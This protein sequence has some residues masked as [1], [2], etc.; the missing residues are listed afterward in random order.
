MLNLRLDEYRK[1]APAVTA[2][3]R[4][5]AQFLHGEHLFDPRFLPYGSQL[6]PL[7]AALAVLGADAEPVGSRQKIARWYWCGRSG[8]GELYGG[9]TENRFARDLPDLISWVHGDGDEPR[10][11]QEA[12]FFASRLRSLRT[13]GSAAYKGLYALLIKGGA[14]DWRTGSGMSVENYFD[15]AVDIHHVF[16]KAWC[17]HKGIKA[18]DYNSILNKTPLTAKTNRIIGGRAPSSYLTRL[19]GSAQATTDQIAY[20][21]KTHVIDP[22]PLTADDYAAFIAAR[23]RSL[24]A[25]VSSAMGKSAQID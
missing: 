6:I 7:A 25:L 22:A 8:P 4:L 18:S 11:V 17:E 15:N 2:G 5:T 23:E 21:V 9:T 14:V 13:R 10:T 3:F 24:L 19:A 20:N 16:P 1:W 12:Q